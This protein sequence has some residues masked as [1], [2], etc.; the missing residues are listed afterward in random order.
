MDSKARDP[1]I[2]RTVAHYRV[3]ERLGSGGMGVVYKAEDLLLERQVA[4]KLLHPGRQDEVARQRFL[5]EA[6]AASCLDHPNVCTVYEIEESLDGSLVLAMALCPG[7]TLA[8]HLARGPLELETALDF[9]AQIAAGL[10]HAHGRDIVHRDVKPSNLIL[11]PAG[12]VKIVDFGIAVR[13]AGPRL[14]RAGSAVGTISYMSPEQLRGGA[15]DHRADIWSLGVVLYEMLT[16][17]LPF[18]APTDAD[19]VAEVLTASPRKVSELRGD[20]PDWVW[21]PL[22]RM[23]VKRPDLRYER[24]ESPIQELQAR[25]EG[26]EVVAPDPQ[27]AVTASPTTVIGPALRSPKTVEIEVHPRVG[28]MFVGR[29]EEMRRLEQHLLADTSSTPANPVCALQGMA[30][31]GKSYLADRFALDRTG[32]PAGR[33]PGGCIRL[34]LD[35]KVPAAPSALLVELADRLAAVGDGLAERVRDRLRRPRTL[36]LIENVD[37]PAAELAAGRLLRELPGCAALV[38][39]RLHGLGLALGWHQVRMSPFDE[40]T[41]LSQLWGELG[42]K[43]SPEEEV[44]HRELV[45]S[46]GFLPLAVHLAAGHLRSGRSATGFLRM[47]RQRRLA[48]TPAD[49]AE[50]ALGV[51]EETRRVLASSFSISLEIVREEIGPDAHRLLPGLHALGHAPL[52]GFG[53]SLGAALAGLGDDDF[54]ELVFH[55][56]KLGLFL[57]VSRTERPDGAWRIHPLL[58]ELLGSGIDPS[59]VLDRMTG[60]FVDRLPTAAPGE[61]TDQGRRWREIGAESAALTGWLP[62]VPAADRWRVQQAGNWYAVWNGPYGVWTEFCEMVLREVDEPRQ[63]QDFLWTLCYMTLRH[64]PLDRSLEAA[65]EKL[66]IDQR[67][68]DEHEESVSWGLIAEILRARGSLDETVAIRREKQ[69]PIL[70]RLGDHRERAIA[71][72]NMAHIFRLQGRFDEALEVLREALPALEE[73]GD[74]RSRAAAWGEIADVLQARGDLEEALRIRQAEELPTY[75]MLGEMRSAAVATGKIAGV[76]HARGEHEAALRIRQ[77]EEKPIYERLGAT[78]ELAVCLGRIADILRSLGRIDEAVRL[79]VA[80]QIPLLEGLGSTSDLVL[81]WQGLAELLLER[82]QP[83]DREQAAALLRTALA[84]AAGSRL[85]A[86]TRI[87]ALLDAH[88]LV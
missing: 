77:E 22:A 65:Q 66:E 73:A 3:V 28:D 78:R 74:M 21:P 59:T 27:A 48:L 38:T 80:E 62:R 57:P 25:W 17:A 40:E 13:P 72:A 32:G 42:W 55:A 26:R 35:P 49:R 64:G 18:D 84:D 76:L 60:W 67:L 46:L 29:E 37:S 70:E 75:Q 2:G 85:S 47:L 88:G 20:L 87:R 69:I 83:G 50:L 58:A 7:E 44:S 54:E 36:L 41:A 63:R 45:R 10:A 4:L 34:V 19:Y 1:W 39:G 33:F 24:I 11:T 8:A 51:A 30:G 82:G 16:C 86:E 5:H 53:R 23:L 31:V 61:E 52:S 71:L 56:Q 79:L 6:R 43:P 68:G 14:T 15:V 12:Q 9:A 81:A